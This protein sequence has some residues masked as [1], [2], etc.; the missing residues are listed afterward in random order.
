MENKKQLIII[1]PMS[2]ALRKLHEVLDGIT[3]DENVE[4]T[5]IDDLRELSQFLGTTGQRGQ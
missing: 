5:L 4:I 1:P 3:S 2:E